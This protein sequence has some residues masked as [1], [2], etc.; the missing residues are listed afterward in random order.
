MHEMKIQMELRVA[1]DLLGRPKKMEVN[2]AGI[3]D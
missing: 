2:L 1:I 3:M